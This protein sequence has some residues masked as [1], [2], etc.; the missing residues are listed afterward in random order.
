MKDEILNP[1][2]TLLTHS[3]R[4]YVAVYCTGGR[5]LPGVLVQHVHCV[6]VEELLRDPRGLEGG[7]RAVPDTT[8]RGGLHKK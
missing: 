3:T 7:G 2:A 6:S 5:Y 1:S 4:G 8:A